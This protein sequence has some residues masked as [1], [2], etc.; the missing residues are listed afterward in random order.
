M[1]GPMLGVLADS[2]RFPISY[3][4]RRMPPRSGRWALHPGHVEALMLG[5]FSCDLQNAWLHAVT[6]NGGY[7]HGRRSRTRRGSMGGRA[8]A[9]LELRPAQVA[10]ERARA[11]R[12]LRA[13]VAGWRDAALA[14]GPV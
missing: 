4:A 2:S 9:C 12:H 3:V 6:M 7:G 11:C 13:A 14:A 10:A 1:P 5:S 8:G